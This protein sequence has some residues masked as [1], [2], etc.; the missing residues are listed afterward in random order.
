ME[1]EAVDE[2]TISKILVAEGTDGVKVGAPIAILAGR[3]RGCFRGSC[4]RAEERR[5]APKP[6]AEPPSRQARASG[7]GRRRNSCRAPQ[8][9]AAPRP[10][11]ARAEGDRIKASPLARRLAEAQGIDLAALKG[12]GPGGRIVRADLGEAAGGLMAAPRAATAPAGLQP[13]EAELAFTDGVPHEVGQAFQHAQDDRA[14]PDR[15]EAA[16]PAYLSD[17]RLPAR[18]LAQAARRIE[19]GAREARRQ[20]QR[21]RSADQGA[22]A[23][24]DRSA[25]MQRQ[26]R[27]RHFDQIQPRRHF[28]RGVDPR[29]A[30]HADRRRAR[31]PS[32]SPRSARK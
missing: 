13:V 10:A 15:V 1:F 14:A 27:R 17:G 28:G 9:A 30:D 20:A 8:P 22:R 16:D 2:G 24:A 32:R 4:A 11:P 31:N 26:L 5:N 19:R 23:G 12:S 3:G 18:C 25:R 29:R 7:Q 21:Q 6:K